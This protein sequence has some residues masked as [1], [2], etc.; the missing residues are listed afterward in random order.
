[1]NIV[2]FASV[3]FGADALR[4]E[5]QPHSITCVSRVVHVREKMTLNMYLDFHDCLM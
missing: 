2:Y 5:A 3:S 4:W 1:M